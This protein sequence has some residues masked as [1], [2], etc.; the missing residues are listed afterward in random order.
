[1]TNTYLRFPELSNSLVHSNPLGDAM[2]KGALVVLFLISSLSHAQQGSSIQLTVDA[3]DTPRKIL[4][5]KMTIP[6]AAGPLM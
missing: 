2:R 6:A 4:H 3:T 5:A 1:M